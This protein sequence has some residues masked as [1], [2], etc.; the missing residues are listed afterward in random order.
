M[1]AAG[2][3]TAAARL[4]EPLWTDCA[5]E[6]VARAEDGLVTAGV[7]T[8]SVVCVISS[9]VRELV[10]ALAEDADEEE[11]EEPVSA[12]GRSGR[13]FRRD[14]V[15]GVSLLVG[16]ETSVGVRSDV[17]PRPGAVGEGVDAEPL[18][19]SP[20][21]PERAGP[22]WVA[23]RLLVRVVGLFGELSFEPVEPA[24]PVVSANATDGIAA[25]AAPTPKATARAPTRPT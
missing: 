18:D 9:G 17:L 20:R 7:T 2:A 12:A 21:L 16:V 14:L 19:S 24:E 1:A 15:A 13:V 11:E 25:T 8:G 5:P 6:S 22:D 10:G 4:A 23:D 3:A